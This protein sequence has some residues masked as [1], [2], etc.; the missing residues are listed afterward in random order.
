MPAYNRQIIGKALKWGIVND[1][2]DSFVWEIGHTSPFSSPAFDFSSVP[3]E[4]TCD[5][6]NGP[7]WAKT[8]PI[9][10]I[11]VTFAD[12]SHPQHWAVVSDYGGKDEV[13]TY[14]GSVRR[15]V[16]ASTVVLLSSSGSWHYG[17]HFPDTVADYG[18]AGTAS[19]SR[20]V[21]SSWTGHTYCDRY[22]DDLM[23][24]AVSGREPSQVPGGPRCHGHPTS[25]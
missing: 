14:C 2:P 17:V 16:S 13:K 7:S 6:Y 22:V 8:V 10:I 5:S 24:G 20:T 15:A 9:D 4:T 3:G 11:S 18:P 25:S 19:R 12:G 21:G 23:G 1:T